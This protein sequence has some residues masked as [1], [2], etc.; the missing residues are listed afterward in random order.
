MAAPCLLFET[1]F[2]SAPTRQ[3]ASSMSSSSL[4]H[5]H[6]APAS[7]QVDDFERTRDALP[8]AARDTYA[9]GPDEVCAWSA[10]PRSA[11]RPCQFASWAWCPASAR[12]YILQLLDGK[13]FVTGHNKGYSAAVAVP[14]CLTKLHCRIPSGAAAAAATDGGPDAPMTPS[15]FIAARRPQPPPLCKRARLADVV[16]SC[17][18]AS[19]A[20]CS[21]SPFARECVAVGEWVAR[22]GATS[23]AVAPSTGTSTEAG[24]RSQ[25]DKDD[26]DEDEDDAPVACGVLRDSS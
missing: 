9:F 1:R 26:E 16:H 22:R 7:S 4:M 20:S 6:P 10:T 3:F 19:A 15:P 12:C 21:H 2:F 11:P 13:R 14:G 18:H 23:S 5:P 8:P 25:V 24:D 17:G